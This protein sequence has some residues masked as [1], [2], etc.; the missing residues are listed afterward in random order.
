MH[1]FLH[2]FSVPSLSSCSNSLRALSARDRAGDAQVRMLIEQEQT[3][4]T[5]LR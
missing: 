2:G 5:E 3:E 1:Q 4:I